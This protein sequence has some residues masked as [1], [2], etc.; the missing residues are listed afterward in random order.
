MSELCFKISDELLTKI[1][2]KLEDQGSGFYHNREIIRSARDN[3]C[4]LVLLYDGDLVSFVTWEESSRNS[5]ASGLCAE[6]F[7][8]HRRKGYMKRLWQATES[9][10]IGRGFRGLR[11]ECMPRESEPCWGALGF[12][13]I[14]SG[15]S[16][17][18]MVREF[19]HDEILGEIVG[20][21]TVTISERDAF[22]VFEKY[23]SLD[24]DVFGPRRI[25]IPFQDP[26]LKI[27]SGSGTP[28]YGKPKWLLHPHALKDGYIEIVNIYEDFI[29]SAA[30]GLN[31]VMLESGK[32]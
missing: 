9:L 15:C 19:P 24:G 7:E 18:V 21:L 13:R 1:I 8:P 4:M 20:S 25:P 10:L 29:N 16:E 5:E 22:I 23:I 2:E 30:I 11:L 28:L 3:D 31:V 14:W 27:D 26:R 12:Q 32:A 6:T 17:I